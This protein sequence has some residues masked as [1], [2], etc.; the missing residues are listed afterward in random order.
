[1]RA[2]LVDE[3]IGYDRSLVVVGEREREG[4]HGGGGFVV[5][6]SSVD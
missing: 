1:M 6:A 5:V 3:G 4:K 2:K